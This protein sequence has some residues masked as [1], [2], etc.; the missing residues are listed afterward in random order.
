M[1]NSEQSFFD[2][3]EREIER[4]HREEID[5]MN[6]VHRLRMWSD[7]YR[8]FLIGM[9]SLAATLALM[10]AGAPEW[11]SCL[12][13]PGA[14]YCSWKLAPMMLLPPSELH[15]DDSGSGPENVNPLPCQ[16]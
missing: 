1:D 13:L 16:F 3:V 14:F 10:M 9:S 12:P 5:A 6:R 15:V 4:R 2:T 11:V 7:I 8:P